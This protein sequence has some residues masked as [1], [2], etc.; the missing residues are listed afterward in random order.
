MACPVLPSRAIV[1]A[2]DASERLED[3]SLV[4]VVD[5]SVAAPLAVT[6][7]EALVAVDEVS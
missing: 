6:L 1:L 7:G 3:W 4:D 2:G 5:T